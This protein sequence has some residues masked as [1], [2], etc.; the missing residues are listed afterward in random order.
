MLTNNKHYKKFNIDDLTIDENFA[1][2]LYYKEGNDFVLAFSNSKVT[3]SVYYRL[4]R[5]E[6]AH[7]SLLVE[8]TEPNQTMH[9]DNKTDKQFF[10]DLN[11]YEENIGETEKFFNSTFNSETI[12]TSTVSVIVDNI[13]S[14][15]QTTNSV[16]LIRLMNNVRNVDKYLYNHSVNV[17]YLNGII[18]KWLGYSDMQIEKLITVGFL[19]D[20][21]KTRTPVEI[22]NKPSALTDEEF[23][24]IKQHPVESY[25]ILLKAGEYDA[26]ILNSVRAHHE[27]INGTGYPDKLTLNEIPPF[28]RITTISDIYDAMAAKRIYKKASSPFDILAEFAKDKFSGLDPRFVNVFL[29]NIPKEFIGKKVSLSNGTTGIVHFINTEDFAYPF[30]NVDGEIIKTSK[31]LKCVRIL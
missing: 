4:S 25:K 1:G 13:N 26:E 19:H 29:K 15:L 9:Q 18:G 23:E 14:H 30:V 10:I 31:D 8:T 6:F 22:L 24:I 3:K 27:K 16:N 5:I 28:A 12:N 7:G 21:G 2:S 20:I 17:S 11:T